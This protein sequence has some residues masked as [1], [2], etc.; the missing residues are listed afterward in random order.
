MAT[1]LFYSQILWIRNSER[2]E[3]AGFISVSQYLRVQ[4]RSP[5]GWAL[6]SSKDWFTLGGGW[7]C[8]SDEIY[9]IHAL[10]MWLI[11]LMA[12]WLDLKSKCLKKTRGW[13]ED[14]SLPSK[15]IFTW[16][17]CFL[18]KLSI[19]GSFQQVSTWRYKNSVLENLYLMTDWDNNGESEGHQRYHEGHIQT[20]IT[21]LYKN[22]T[23]KWWRIYNFVDN[24]PF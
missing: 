24:L 17:Q 14:S 10:S 7:W 12:V 3:W 8:P 16:H 21:A 18:P 23:A 2:T 15:H 1:I 9:S 11:F 19:E 4:L 6:T 20:E 22:H 13:K 5:S